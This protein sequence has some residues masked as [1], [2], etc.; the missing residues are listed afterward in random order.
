MTERLF[1][2]NRN[3][4]VNY[5]VIIPLNVPLNFLTDYITATAS[6]LKVNNQVMFLNYQDPISIF[7]LVTKKKDRFKFWLSVK[8]LYAPIK[9]G[10][11][12]FKLIGIFP[13][14]RIHFFKRVNIYLG[15]LQL[16][17]IFTFLKNKQILCWGFHPVLLYLIQVLKINLSVYDCLDYY[18]SEI[19]NGAELYKMEK[20]LLNEVTL[21]SFCSKTLLNIKKC[22]HPGIDTKAI[23]ISM[24]CNFSLF[25]KA[26]VYQFGSL[27][28]KKRIGIF[29]HFNFRLDYKLLRE[30]ISLHP[31]WSF[32]FG[33]PIYIEKN[34][35]LTENVHKNVTILKSYKNV[36]FLGKI[37]KNKL[38]Q[39][40]N[41][42]TVCLIPYRTDFPAA[43]YCNPMKAY[44][45]LACGKPIVST[46]LPA[47]RELN[48]ECIQFASTSDDF[49]K[50]IKYFLNHWSVADRLNAKKIAYK[51]RWEKRVLIL[52]KE[53]FKR[54]GA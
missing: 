50:K 45:Y 2:H 39:Y 10:S 34:E 46:P 4:L 41:S 31:N 8:K 51:H 27:L 23:A 14:Q 18:G 28:G 29:G 3:K 47:L 32:V 13:F 17:L 54:T 25:N 9:F 7:S 24:G 30:L 15:F 44:E 52:Q 49:S 20:K 42:I 48:L 1:L 43:K 11:F 36:F 33:G 22:E 5:L 26:R 19:E 38:V 35:D 6:I 12:E 53:L 40:I 16:K 21:A 37:S